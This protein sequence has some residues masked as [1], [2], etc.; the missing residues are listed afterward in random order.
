M[1]TGVFQFKVMS[2]VVPKMQADNVAWTSKDK[3]KATK[4]SS[5]KARK[6]SLIIPILI[7]PKN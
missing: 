5:L 6:L 7:S 1:A 2:Y 4:I 3:I